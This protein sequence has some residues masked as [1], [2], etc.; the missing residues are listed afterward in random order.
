MVIFCSLPVPRSF[1]ETFRMPFASMSNVTS[2]CGTPRGAGGIES[3]WNLPMVL[4][5]AAIGRS[6]CRTWISTDGWLSLAVLK[7]SFFLVGMVVLRSII[8]VKTP[9]RVSMPS[10]SG[11]TSSRRTSLTSLFRTPPWMA[12]PMATT[13]SGLTP[14]LAGLPKISSASFWTRGIRV[15]PPTRMTSLISELLS[16]ASRRQLRHG[17]FERAE[18]CSVSCSSIARLNVFVKCF[19]PVASAVM[20]GRLI[21]VEVLEDS[22]HFAFSA[23]SFKR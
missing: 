23:A 14:L 4:L 12:A 22:S 21:S 17:F 2:I 20:N 7:I 3:R 10:D 13:S 16:E 6:P 1:A 15:M 18:R 5:S 8:F 11:V 19:G 9:P